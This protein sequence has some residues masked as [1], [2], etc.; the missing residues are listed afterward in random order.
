MRVGEG[1]WQPRFRLRPDHPTNQADYALV[2]AVRRR[3]MVTE[4]P[5]GRRPYNRIASAK[6]LP[7]LLLHV[8]VCEELAQTFEVVPHVQYQEL[9]C[10]SR[11]QV[12]RHVDVMA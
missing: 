11:G 4:E 3:K 2:L 6:N 5:L 9:P 1:V 8:R 7:A 12:G 10:A